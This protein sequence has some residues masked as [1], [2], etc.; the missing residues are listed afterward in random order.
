MDQC[1]K[2][3]KGPTQNLKI[4]L[5]KLKAILPKFIENTI[6]ENF[7]GYELHSEST[8]RL[9]SASKVTSPIQTFNTLFLAS[10]SL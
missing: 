2:K 9:H 7:E 5:G 3:Y 1:G 4:S 10:L 6:V 8:V